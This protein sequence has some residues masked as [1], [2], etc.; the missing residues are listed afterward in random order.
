MPEAKGN[1]FVHLEL[2]SP[3][4]KKAKDF[5]A[6]MFGWEITDMDMGPAGIYSTFKPADG[7]G[8]GMFSI[9]DAPTGWLPYI[10]VDDIKVATAKARE[11]GAKV[12]VDSHEIPHVGWMTVMN[13]PTGCRVAIFQ[14][15][16]ESRQ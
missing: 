6:G 13:D 9:N 2:N 11:L 16:P 10:G 8:G 1:G 14:P 4:A 7:P 15:A 12:E 5:Y 3:D